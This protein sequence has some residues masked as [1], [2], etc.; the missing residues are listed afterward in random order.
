[1]SLALSHF[2]EPA[3]RKGSF[4]IQ[5]QEK[6]PIQKLTGFSCLDVKR[7]Q[8][9]NHHNCCTSLH[10]HTSATVVYMLLDV[11]IDQK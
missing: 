9:C 5:I 10:E 1:M 4:W 3:W 11:I 7:K 2:S 6:F 8:H